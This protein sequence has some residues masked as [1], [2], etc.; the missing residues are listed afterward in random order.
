M[1]VTPTEEAAGT[2]AASIEVPCIE[3]QSHPHVY[4]CY[5]HHVSV[6]AGS[7]AAASPA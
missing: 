1:V 2:A 6:G 4:D 7:T 3:L 5:T